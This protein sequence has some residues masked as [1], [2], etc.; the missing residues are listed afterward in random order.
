MKALRYYG[1]E[2][3]RVEEVDEPV[4][5]E[6]QIKI[7]PAFVGICGSGPG[8]CPESPHPVTGEKIPITLGHEFSE[9]GT[10]IEVGAGVTGFETG[11]KVAVRPTIADGSCGACKRGLDNV[12]YK[13]GFVGLSGWGGGLSGAV[14]I[15]SE[16]VHLLP[17]N[18]P[19]DVG[20][21]VEPLSVGWHAVRQSPLTPSSSILILG[22]GPIGIAIINALKAR[23]CGQIIVSE[24]TSSR[25][26][27]AKDFGADTVL[28]PVMDD[29]EK[30]VMELT[31]GE[32]VDI[33]FDCAGVEVGLKAACMVIKPHGT[34]VNVA[35]WE[36]SVPFN[37][38]WLVHREGKYIGTIGYLRQDFE[39]TI[40]AIAS[41]S[42]SPS[43]MIT[44]KISLPNVERDGFKELIHNKEKH[45]KILVEL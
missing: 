17:S 36:K 39:E 21:L 22:G 4:C 14:S 33:V 25:Q 8:F 38:N 20:A 24:P 6:G 9:S 31:G 7:K 32:G 44:S 16:L 10:I 35:I 41:G 45:V 29:V 40:Q 34:V 1:K 15:P 37:P 28:N 19:L 42:L 3:I 18:I 12:C 26:K 2:D 43:R 13:G 27:F 5:K 23:E 30:K 11:Q